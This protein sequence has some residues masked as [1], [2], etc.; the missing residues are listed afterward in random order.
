[1]YLKQGPKKVV[2]TWQVEEDVLAFVTYLQNEIFQETRGKRSKTYVRPSD[3]LN[4]VMRYIESRMLTRETLTIRQLLG[5]DP[6]VAAYK[7][8]TEVE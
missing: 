7:P 4:V 2:K 6:E 5:L 1:V 3:V 8:E